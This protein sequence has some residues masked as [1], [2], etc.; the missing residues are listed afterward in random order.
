[1]G[2][3][4]L[5]QMKAKICYQSSTLTFTYAGVTIIK[6]LTNNSSGNKLTNSGERAGHLRI[7][8]RSETIV[9]LAAETGSTTAEGIVERKELLPGVYLAGSQ[10]SNADALSRIGSVPAEPKD[11]TKLDEE[12]KK[13][14]LYEFHDARV[15]GHRGMN[16]TFRAI[17]SR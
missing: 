14:I 9:R 15:G 12:T 5:K 2:R 16:K 17:K 7:P 11:S 13:Q 3:D 4:F 10:N 1:M 8:P 6:S